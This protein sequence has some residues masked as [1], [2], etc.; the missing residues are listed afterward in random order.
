[1]KMGVLSFSCRY[2]RYSIPMSKWKCTLFYFSVV[3]VVVHVFEVTPLAFET[4]IKI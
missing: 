2:C 1:M 3:Y 4:S